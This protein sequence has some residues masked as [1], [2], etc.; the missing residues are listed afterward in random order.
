[1]DDHENL[2][3][4]VNK[5]IEDCQGEVKERNTRLY[6]RNVLL[7]LLGFA[8]FTAIIVLLSW[9]AILQYYFGRHGSPHPG[10]RNE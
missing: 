8:L 2:V 9:I 3:A 7:V 6:R 1:M 5:A 4:L 10:R